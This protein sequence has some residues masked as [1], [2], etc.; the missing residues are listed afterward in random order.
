[1]YEDEWKDFV[2]EQYQEELDEDADLSWGGILF[3]FISAAIVI[4][5]IVIAALHI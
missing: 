3:C 4:G 2:N 1:M 5:G